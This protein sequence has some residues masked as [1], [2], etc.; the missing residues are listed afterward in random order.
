MIFMC[1]SLGQGLTSLGQPRTSKAYL[2]LDPW[3]YTGRKGGVPDDLGWN[4]TCGDTC[5]GPQG[6]LG[7]FSSRRRE[8]YRR[9]TPWD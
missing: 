6:S 4:H 2:A 1:P 8:V 5:L 3:S 9:K 7:P